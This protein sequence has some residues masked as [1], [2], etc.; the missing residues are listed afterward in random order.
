M[1]ILIGI[2][3]NEANVSNR[4]GVN[5][6]AFEIV[7][8]IYRLV[9]ERK[10]PIRVKVYLKNSPLPEMP[11]SN[12]HFDYEVIKGSGVWILTKLTPHLF[13]TKDRPDVFLSLSH[14]VP[15]F[16]P[17][18]RVCSIMDLGYLVF[19]A[20]FKK[21]DFWQ[22]KLWSAW[23]IKVSRR[24]IAISEST[25]QDIVRHYPM[26]EGKI[27]IVPLAYSQEKFNKDISISEVER[28]KRKYTIVN[29]YILFISTLK[30]SKNI[31]GLLEAWG[32]IVVDYPDYQLVIAGKKGWLYESIFEKS[33]EL[34]LKEK[35]VFT[36]YLPEE[37]KPALIKGA[38]L[39]T[40]PSFWEGFGLDPLYAMAVGVPV[41]VSNRGSLPEV[42]GD[43]GILVNPYKVEEIESGIR[44]VLTMNKKEYN[45]LIRKGFSQ[46]SKF[47][48][49]ESSKKVLDIL[50]EVV[51]EN[52]V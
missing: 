11:P 14:Y 18:P 39:L 41:V 21:Y 48:W 49:K 37:D 47:S 25:K 44:K 2:D 42:V 40:L 29:G 1:S 36:D 23:S 6:Y 10:G 19:S 17:M 32:K 38:K 15:M 45:N 35:V 8:G 28:V 4:V 30:P 46:S 51:K 24:V 50:E 7:W 33:K 27:D 43:A 34:G 26:S 12:K 13:K 5:E 22:L 9:T 20:Q 16:A 31:E 52:N 3:G